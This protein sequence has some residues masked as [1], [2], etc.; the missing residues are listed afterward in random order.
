MDFRGHRDRALLEKK[1]Y[2]NNRKINKNGDYCA[3]PR[4]QIF[5]LPPNE[6][7]KITQIKKVNFL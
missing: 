2:D 1:Q 5:A 3:R 6:N 7:K 4:K